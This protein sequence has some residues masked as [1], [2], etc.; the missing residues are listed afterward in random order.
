MAETADAPRDRAPD[1]AGRPA[2]GRPRE[3]VGRAV[4]GGDGRCA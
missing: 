4:V 1:L 2:V 3:A